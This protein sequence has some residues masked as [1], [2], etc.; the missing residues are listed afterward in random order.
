MA[1]DPY[2]SFKSLQFD[3]PSPGVLRIV[4]DTPGRLNAVDRAKH[5]EL[6]EVWKAVDTDAETRVA[7]IRG[8]GGAFSAGGDLDMAR[9]IAT[10]FGTRVQ[11]MREARDLVY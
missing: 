4:I 1:D 11:V 3:R 9:E 10:D 5:F 8:A 6:A 2:A 7:L